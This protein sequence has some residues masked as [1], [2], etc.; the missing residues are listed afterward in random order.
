MEEIEIIK[1]NRNFFNNDGGYILVQLVV[2]LMGFGTN[3]LFNN[4]QGICS[5]KM[6][7]IVNGN[8]SNHKIRKIVLV[9]HGWLI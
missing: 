7:F 2:I 8:S 6:K 3:A 5:E 9:Q 4:P 1:E